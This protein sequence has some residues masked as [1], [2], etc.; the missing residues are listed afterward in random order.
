MSEGL[1]FGIGDFSEKGINCLSVAA[2]T[3]QDPFVTMD[4]FCTP[5]T[6]AML[7]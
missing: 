6:V 1:I 4:A 7:M 5:C 2:D 3:M